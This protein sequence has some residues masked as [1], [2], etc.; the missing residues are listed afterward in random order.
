MIIRNMV[1][2]SCLWNQDIKSSISK[3]LCQRIC[4]VISKIIQ[5]L[6]N[7]KLEIQVRRVGQADTDAW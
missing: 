4:W 2:M 7:V 3:D 5:N 1:F 6:K